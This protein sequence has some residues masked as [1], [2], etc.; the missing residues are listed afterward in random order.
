M[1]KEILTQNAPQPT[2][3]YS[4]GLEADGFIFVSGQDGVHPNG[5]LAGDS[6]TEQ[7]IACLK[8]IEQILKKAGA[9]LNDIVHMTCHLAD[10]SKDNVYAFNQV[11]AAYFE[12]VDSKPA[13]ITVGSVLMETSVEITAIAYRKKE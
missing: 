9:G 13:R 2:G 5:E 4:Q 11:Y 10:L 12:N 3:P 6:I 1:K 8:N 7:T